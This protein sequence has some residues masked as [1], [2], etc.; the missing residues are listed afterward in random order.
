M[1]HYLDLAKWLIINF[2][3]SGGAYADVILN[4]EGGITD[5][6]LRNGGQFV[7]CADIELKIYL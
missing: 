1:K 4:L 6:I 3:N 2:I 5:V 7:D